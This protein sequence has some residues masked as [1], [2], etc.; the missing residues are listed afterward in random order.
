MGAGAET[1]TASDTRAGASVIGTSITSPTRKARLT[2]TGAK[3][4][5]STDK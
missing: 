5:A 1:S 3:P 4:G 2:L